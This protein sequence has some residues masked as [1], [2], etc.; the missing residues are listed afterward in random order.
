MF[1]NSESNPY[2]VTFAGSDDTVP[3]HMIT[4]KIPLVDLACSS[5]DS[6]L[7]HHSSNAVSDVS[8]EPI[9][10]TYAIEKGEQTDVHSSRASAHQVVVQ[11]IYC[12][13]SPALLNDD[14]VTNSS[15]INTAQSE[16][17]RV[18]L[19]LFDC[20]KVP[21]THSIAE[22]SESNSNM[23]V[24]Q[25]LDDSKFNHELHDKSKEEPAGMDDLIKTA[26]ESLI[27]ISLGPPASYHDCSSKEG[28]HELEAEETQPQ[29]SFD[30]FESITLRLKERSGD[31]DYCATSKPFEEN[32]KGN[33]FGFKLRRGRRLKDFRKDILPG[34]AALSRHEICEDINIF[35]GVMRSREYRKIQSRMAND[36]ENWR[37]PVRSKRSRASNIRRGSY[38]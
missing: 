21:K 6:I 3:D 35:K 16:T 22:T 25:S 18:D 23:C 38:R 33:D 17:E 20:N 11:D 31:D 36:V 2:L 13:H 14:P 28:S 10:K 12:N 1:K 7:G 30:S 9:A 5:E 34:L 15:G 37:V 26:A 19:N 24:R 8:H 27:C 32:E 29:K 4:K